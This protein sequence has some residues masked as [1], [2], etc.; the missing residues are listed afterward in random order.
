M[1]SSEAQIMRMQIN[2]QYDSQQEAPDPNVE[3]NNT[4][5]IRSYIKPKI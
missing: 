1:G 4:P 2:E 3:V 5:F